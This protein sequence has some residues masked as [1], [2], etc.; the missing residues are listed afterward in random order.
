MR[1]ATY[2]VHG[3]A[4]RDG[5]FGPGRI[6]EVSVEI[7]VD[8]IALQKVTL[9]RVGHLTGHFEKTPLLVAMDSRLA[10]SDVGSC[11]NLVWPHDSF[12]NG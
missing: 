8:L 10:E 6:A 5:R 4:G 9:N 11:G 2:N 12:G 1:V 3:C 7:E